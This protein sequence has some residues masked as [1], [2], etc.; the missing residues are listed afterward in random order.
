MKAYHSYVRQKNSKRGIALS[1]AMAVCI[2]L[3]LLTAI[4]VSM[5]TLNITTT[6]TSISQRES[7]IQAK[8]AI[9]FAESYYAK[10]PDQIPGNAEGETGGE[11]LFVFKDN[12]IAHGANVYI[13]STSSSPN[14]VPAATVEDLKAKAPD[15][16]LEVKNTG[17]VVDISAYCKY[18]EGDSYKLNKEF[19]YDPSHQA[20][21]NTFT[22]N[23]L[24]N[25]TSDT[26]YLR[27][28]VRTSAAFYNEPYI[29][30]WGNY[31]ESNIPT[32]D[33]DIQN[34]GIAY[35]FGGSASVNKL[36]YDPNYGS[37]K[38]SGEWIDSEDPNLAGPT[39]TMEYEGNGWFVSEIQFSSSNKLNYINA[40]VTRKGAMRKSSGFD[41]AT[42]QSWEIFDIPVPND[43]GTGNGTDVYITLN[44]PNLRDARMV[45]EKSTG[46]KWVDTAR[47]REYNSN[48]STGTDEMTFLFEDSNWGK[49]DIDTFA[50]F[51]SEWYT[52]YTK[53]VSAIVHYKKAGV[54]D[55]SAGKAGFG[56]E[57]YG[58]WRKVSR[59]FDDTVTTDDGRVYY[60]GS[61]TGTTLSYTSDGSDMVT[62]LFVVEGT[63]SSGTNISAE[64]GDENSANEWLV[65]Q[66]ADSS[67]PDYITINAK[68]NEMPVDNVVPTTI[69]YSASIITSAGA[70]PT[71]GSSGGSGSGGSGSSSE[72]DPSGTANTNAA[73]EYE[74]LVKV[75]TAK[76]GDTQS[77]ATWGIAGDF[78][79][80]NWARGDGGSETKYYNY[81]YKTSSDGYIHSYTFKNLAAGDYMYKFVS[82]YEDSGEFKGDE[83]WIGDPAA[84][85]SDHNAT[86]HV[87]NG[88]N[89]TLRFDR[90]NGVILDPIYE[91]I[92]VDYVDPSG[93]S[94]RLF[95][96]ENNWGRDPGSSDSMHYFSKGYA[97]NMEADNYTFYT[98]ILTKGGHT[99][100]MKVVREV[101]G[102]EGLGSS[103]WSGNSWPGED[104]TVTIPG[105]NMDS[106]SVRVYF[107]EIN[108]NVWTD[109]PVLM[110]DI[111]SDKFYVVGSFNAGS[112]YE[113]VTSNKFYLGDTPK[114]EGNYAVYEVD[115][116]KF[117]IGDYWAKVIAVND[118]SAGAIN[119]DNSWGAPNGE[120]VTA[121]S[122]KE[123]VS[124]STDHVYYIKIRFEYDLTNKTKSKITYTKTP[125]SDDTVVTSV[126]VGFLNKQLENV[127]EPHDKTQF[128]TPWSEVY[129]TY[130]TPRGMQV[131]TQIDLSNATEGVVW[132]KLPSD[133]YDVYFSNKTYDL[134]GTEGYEY[135][136]KLPNSRITNNFPKFVPISYDEDTDHNKQWKFGDTDFYRSYTNHVDD[137]HTPTGG[138]QMVWV[139]SYQNNYYNVPIVNLLKEILGTTGN[140]AFSAY[141]YTGAE[142]DKMKIDGQN[143]VFDRKKY[144]KYQGEVYFYIPSTTGYSYLVCQGST[145]DGGGYLKENEFALE[146][147][148]WGDTPTKMN[149]RQGAIFTSDGSYYDGSSA[150]H[151]Y[152]G[153]TPNW[154]TI[155]LPVTDE[156]TIE[157]IKGVV[158]DGYGVISGNSSKTQVAKA[159]DYFNR[160]VYIYYD[161]D[162]QGNTSVKTYTYDTEFGSV[163]TNKDGMVNVY[164]NK[165]SDWSDNVKVHA[166]S[167]IGAAADQ[168]ISVDGTDATS[169]HNYYHFEF[170]AGEFCFFRFYDG[171][172]PGKTTEVLTLTGEENGDHQ[173]KI[174]CDAA[175]G[176]SSE[177]TYYLHP[178]SKALYAWQEARSAKFASTI[179][180]SYTYS[181]SGYEAGTTAPLK[182]LEQLETDA[183]TYYEGSSWT[184]DAAAGYFDKATAARTFAQ[185]IKKARV[186]IAADPTTSD[187]IES[188][189]IFP[190]RESR[191]EIL[192]YEPR[193][194][195]SLRYVH[196]EAMKLYD[197]SA[198]DDITSDLYAF[199]DEIEKIIKFP[200]TILN[201]A[202]IQ[203]IV[204]NQPVYEELHEDPSDPTAVTSTVKNGDWDIGKIRLYTEQAGTIKE[205]GLKLI[206]TTQSSEGFYAYVF[207][208]SKFQTVATD[209]LK[210]NVGRV[211]DVP[212]EVYSLTPGTTYIYH[213][214]T[215]EFEEDKAVHTI[216]CF[217][218][219][220]VKGGKGDAYG[221]YESK[222]YG[223]KIVIMFLHD[224]T[225]KYGTTSYTILAG[226]YT[227]NGSY[228]NF[229][230]DFSSNANTGINLFTDAAKNYF[231]NPKVSGLTKSTTIPAYQDYS[232]GTVSGGGDD[233]D[234][235]AKKLD[236]A[237]AYTFETDASTGRINF[238]WSNTKTSTGATADKL[239]LPGNVSLSA[240]V[241]TVAVNN[242][243]LNSYEFHIEAKK[244]TFFCDT[245][246]T[247]SAGTFTISHG[248]YIFNN[249]SS[250]ATLV[251]IDLST[252]GTAHDWR[253]SY[254][255]VE[256]VKTDLGG[257]KFV[258]K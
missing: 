164:F 83:I 140:Y 27:I 184:D 100:H 162:Y 98:D 47:S 187:P 76:S 134:K 206:E 239:T 188:N 209:P 84:S 173:Y 161:K 114:I 141:P 210:F 228:P 196:D 180:R 43:N 120:G 225:V 31:V 232:P 91:K 178:H 10:N 205:A 73:L 74:N 81:L 248:T 26:R 23:I 20:K 94:Y 136:E 95:C 168:S 241:A 103:G 149:N 191:D 18:G 30:T 237:G 251:P 224:T 183:K 96:D 44:Q 56:Y 92:G 245:K 186:Y 135:T 71:P 117:E 148:V 163:D 4:L 229:K 32:K 238:R 38:F 243:D 36:S 189:Y 156:F 192:S 211:T 157:N 126:Q 35:P 121:G 111:S 33:E 88:Y 143:C 220:L 147:G 234:I 175:N 42:A 110:G 6:Q 222:S 37:E 85:N 249:L 240:G 214:A 165:P 105:T 166:Y 57:G 146:D 12:V 219:E 137:F 108:K 45:G 64:F 154:Y 22:G 158:S 215:G 125:V 172:D 151:D 9:A 107:D 171:N 202:A 122:D 153:Y 116:G 69:D 124:F 129:V 89:I 2:I 128:A 221:R 130:T 226:A 106:Y 113:D 223:E 255:L 109:E 200:E 247:T 11:A 203:I 54:T 194:V 235:V 17:A 127:N 60:F 82:M 25:A 201:P 53:Q 233:I 104:C 123:N 256:E 80:N 119:W 218:N 190:E 62:E 244:V 254:I 160:P 19:E 63:N 246:I 102:S 230:N 97:M 49:G 79:G 242:L 250:S 70:D 258:V 46:Y 195:S 142:G 198:D 48:D 101:P 52:I 77:I 155:K 93:E 67:A 169:G 170:N 176:S 179:P 41:G 216:T 236:G 253:K 133:A 152:G 7:Y 8:S 58:W 204:D 59:N 75:P 217:Y 167:I 145:R 185:A 132:A 150:A 197:R 15:T 65:N 66:C 1:T 28:H 16:Y 139:G 99:E 24:Y 257:G 90:F 50:Q 21:P 207:M 72:P 78:P 5:A 199:A 51:C 227:I 112:N 86:L 193:W 34:T 68:A 3:A 159:G 40:I 14:L 118:E 29:Y 231:S 55:N 174:L 208:A 181:T 87:E 61:G 138:A 144:I 212:T 39:G 115:L 213:T 131:D 252:T 182:Y 13:T 177:F